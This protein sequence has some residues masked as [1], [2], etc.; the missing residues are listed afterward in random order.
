MNISMSWKEKL[1]KGMA[2]TTAS[3]V[4]YGASMFGAPTPQQEEKPKPPKKPEQE[5]AKIIDENNE[6]AEAYKDKWIFKLQDPVMSAEDTFKETLGKLRIGARYEHTD[7]PD[8][9][10]THYSAGIESEVKEG[11]IRPNLKGNYM[12]GTTNSI[13][14]EGK[15]LTTFDTASFGIEQPVSFRINPKLDIML[16]HAKLKEGET[17]SWNSLYGKIEGE[18]DNLYSEIGYKLGKAQEDTIL[19]DLKG[20]GG[21]YVRDKID[22]EIALIPGIEVRF[23]NELIG[24]GEPNV[25]FYLDLENDRLLRFNPE[26]VKGE[27]G[28]QAEVSYES[29]E[30]VIDPLAKTF[31]K[32]FG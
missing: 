12:L 27:F 1:K 21:L 20:S 7:S 29:L 23:E 28:L 14:T 17:S 6:L 2:I 19:G 8:D 9:L 4:L 15:K 24:N 16:Q 31:K 11:V 26:D 25:S 30:P 32:Y 5:V 22:E 10:F 18:L 13:Q 3:A